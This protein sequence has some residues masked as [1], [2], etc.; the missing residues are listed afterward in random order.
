MKMFALFAS[1]SFRKEI[2]E[3]VQLAL[4]MAFAQ[5]AQV[6]LNFV[7][8][9]MCGKLGPNAIAGVGLGL[10][11]YS[12][13]WCIGLGFVMAV[14]PM[15]AQAFGAQDMP[16][17][18][19]SVRKGM[20][21]GLLLGLPTMVALEF[22][23][24]LIALTKQAP[25]V[26]QLADEY[27]HAVKWSVIPSLWVV[28]L[29]SFLD[30][31]NRPN[32][33]LAVNVTG[34][35]VNIWGNYT[36][37]FGANWSLGGWAWQIPAFGVAGTGYA[38]TLVNIWMF[39]A[40]LVYIA[41]HPEYRAYRLLAGIFKPDWL[42]LQEVVRIGWPIAISMLVE[43]ALFAITAVAMGTLSKTA[44]AAHQ[45]ALNVASITFMFAVGIALA[46]TTRVGQA[47]G[48][49]DA[50]AAKRAGHIG[51]G[52]GMLSMGSMALVFLSIPHTIIGLYLDVNAPKNAA[53]VQMAVTLL[54]LAA[55]FQLFDGLQ[56]TSAG[57]L[58]G[59]KD[60]RT[61]AL[62]GFFSY[63]GIGLV[64]GLVLCFGFGWREV[65]LWSGLITGLGTAGI[66]LFTAFN[67]RFKGDNTFLHY[68]TLE[69]K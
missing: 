35:L 9:V 7:D 24:P 49:G 64:S 65:G 1:A 40:L 31:M 67:R 36:L 8:N 13:L 61:P 57:A 19:R 41:A 51:M 48:R 5:L 32:V 27:L 63:W 10:A 20:W 3:H 33:G 44:L 42:Y 39:L 43:V 58:R 4:P 30:S 18:G 68:Q 21:I 6:A 34:I 12:T 45:I 53:V 16:A 25:I 22:A 62:I 37:M 17:I 59:L 69:K 11:A 2:R 15:V 54:A 14:G 47:V 55:M 66:L 26:I 38:T 50:E 46:T 60:T 23:A 52:L 28:V 56:V 29:R